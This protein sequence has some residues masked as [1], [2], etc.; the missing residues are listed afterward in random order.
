M[1]REQTIPRTTPADGGPEPGAEGLEQLRLDSAE[2]LDAMDRI[3]D[4]VQVVNPEEYL[5]RNRQPGG[6]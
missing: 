2:I 6:E 4:S 3:L 1:E 5:Q